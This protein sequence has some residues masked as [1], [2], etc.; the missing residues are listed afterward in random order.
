MKTA[1]LAVL[2][3]P[4]LILAGGA[5]DPSTG[6]GSGATSVKKHGYAAVNGLKM[7]YEIHGEGGTPLILLHGGGSTIETTFGKILPFLAK[8]R[9]VIAFEQQ[10][11]G[12][13]ADIADRPFSFEQ[14]AEDTAA[15]LK[16]LKIEKADLFGFSNGGHM[17]LQVAIRHPQ[18]VRKLIVTS[19]GFKRD[20]HYAEFW[21]FMKEV[22]LESMPKELRDAYLKVSPHPEQLPTFFEK[23]AKR[24]REF[25]GW[26]SEDIRSIKAPPLVM[27]GDADNVRPEHAV[28]MF[29]LLQHAQL[30]V[31][32]GGH[33]A[34]IGEVSAAR[35]DGS[36]V[37][38]GIGDSKKESKLPELVAAMMEEFLDA[39]MPEPRAKKSTGCLKSQRIGAWSVHAVAQ[40]RRPRRGHGAVRS[41]RP[42]RSTVGRRLR[43]GK[44]RR[45]CSGNQQRRGA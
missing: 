4:P 13:T 42:L 16:H 27:V 44:C 10:G 32:P 34:A 1:L 18:F 8:T 17:A 12:R 23:S 30:A 24:M 39:P 45:P 41:G 43:R 40:R 19:A 25:K 15:L 29:R 35:L 31:L 2:L 22:K 36:Q 33:G 28:E 3:A 38:F 21:E 20:G 7:Y 9:Q 5:Q 14:S 26:R 11:H 37:K 6:P